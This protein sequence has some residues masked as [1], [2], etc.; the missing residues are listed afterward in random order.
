MNENGGG[1]WAMEWTSELINV[2]F[3]SR[4]AIPDDITN[5]NP[6]PCSWGTPTADFESQY[7]E[8]DIDGHFPAQT[9]YFDTDFCGP[10]A[11]GRAWTSWTDCSVK[12]NVSTCEEYVAVNP[13]DF[14]EAYWLVNSVK[15]Y[16]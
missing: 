1:V 11:G 2:W 5:E 14:S 12:T 13:T 3:F 10:E 15:V 8:C 4:D 6:D 9:I 16:Q 7:G